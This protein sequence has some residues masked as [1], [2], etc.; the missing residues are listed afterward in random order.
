MS[1][2][3]LFNTLLG[4]ETRLYLYN[5]YLHRL[6][7]NKYVKSFLSF[8]LNTNRLTLILQSP[9]EFDYYRNLSK[10]VRLEFVPY[11]SDIEQQENDVK[12]NDGYIFSGGYSNR[13][14]SL[15]I[16]LAKRMP[17]R[18]FVFVASKLNNDLYDIPSNVL[19]KKDIAI[20]DFSKLLRKAAI[21]VIPLKEDVG[22]SGQ[23]LCLQAMRYHKPI[24]YT[25][26][27]SINYYFTDKSGIG[28]KIG[29]LNSLIASVKT[30]LQNDDIARDMGNMAFNESL[31]Y[32]NTNCMKMIDRIIMN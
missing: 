11:C 18:Q 21:V 5:F 23:M 26:I 2:F 29:D 15:M 28:Y 7:N 25:N 22:S 3:R 27:S 8:L 1:V 31:K 32:T 19:V 30:I 24:V 20:E 17:D 13:D 10:K 9:S 14:Y 6:G 4:T 12:L 16:E